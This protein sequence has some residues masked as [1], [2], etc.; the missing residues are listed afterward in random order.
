MWRLTDAL[1]MDEKT[2]TQIFPLLSKYERK[3]AEVELSLRSSMKELRESLKEKR[4]GNLK[5]ILDKLE[6]NRKT[7]QRIKEE[8]WAEIKKILTIEQQARFILFQQEL[9]P[10][11]HREAETAKAHRG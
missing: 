9:S 3:R 7:L 6:E 5:N 8:E 2:S 10:T 4:E 1:N 11:A